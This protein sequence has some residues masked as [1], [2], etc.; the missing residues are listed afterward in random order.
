MT[1]EQEPTIHGITADMAEE[2]N[3]QQWVNLYRLDPALGEQQ[4]HYVGK[5]QVKDLST[6]LAN[7][8]LSDF[9]VEPLD[10]QGNVISVQQAI[11]NATDS[12]TESI[13]DC[14]EADVMK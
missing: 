12:P 6:I 14:D 13:R 11:N 5:Y 10:E 8:N 7:N 9:A 4:L 3:A 2:L 1:Q